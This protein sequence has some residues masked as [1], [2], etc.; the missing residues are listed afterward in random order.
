MAATDATASDCEMEQP[1]QVYT[2]KDMLMEVFTVQSGLEPDEELAASAVE[3]LMQAK[4]TKAW[5]LRKLS[6]KLLEKVVS[7]DDNLQE[8]LLISEVRD[9]LVK[10]QSEPTPPPQQAQIPNPDG[11]SMMAEALNSLRAENAKQREETA[12]ARKQRKKNRSSDSEDE[13]PAE[14]N[15]TKS[16]EQYGLY[17][18]PN[19]HLPRDTEMESQAKKAATAYKQRGS[20]FG[21]GAGYVVCSD[22]VQERTYSKVS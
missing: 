22:V 3:L 16:L 8:F 7:S 1:T 10:W 20:F 2:D 9:L 15:C 18:V 13:L 6:D 11:M 21:K 5:Q 4:I 14:Y 17:G 12:K 19:T